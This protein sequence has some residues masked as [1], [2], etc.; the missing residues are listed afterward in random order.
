MYKFK[1]T[2]DCYTTGIPDPYCIGDS[3]ATVLLEKEFLSMRGYDFSFLIHEQG[4]HIS[5]HGFNV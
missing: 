1:N 4:N 3:L 2:Y 5:K